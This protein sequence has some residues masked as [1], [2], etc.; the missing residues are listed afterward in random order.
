MK[1]ALR[2]AEGLFAESAAGERV[3]LLD[4]PIMAA[5]LSLEQCLVQSSPATT[6]I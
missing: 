5:L 3:P 4:E 1:I 6:I 2:V